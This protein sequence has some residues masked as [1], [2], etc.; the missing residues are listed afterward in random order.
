MCA[1]LGIKTPSQLRKSASRRPDAE[2]RIHTRTRLGLQSF[3][4]Q[5]NG[6]HPP[7]VPEHSCQFRQKYALYVGSG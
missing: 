5:A 1:A 6:S 4:H 3:P 7:K 2:F